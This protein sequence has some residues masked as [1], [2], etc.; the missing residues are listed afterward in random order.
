MDEMAF[1][2]PVRIGDLVHA[3]GRVNW[4]GRTSLEVGVRVLAEPW[5][6]LQTAKRVATAY[7]VFVALDSSGRPRRVPPVLP[8]TEEDRRRFA[9]AEIRRTLIS[10]R[11]RAS[12]KVPDVVSS[13]SD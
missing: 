5:N 13:S 3:H 12:G 7:V 2:E 1:L 9:E 6:A 10:I 11:D 8:E 4:T